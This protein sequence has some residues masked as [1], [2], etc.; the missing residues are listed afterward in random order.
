MESFGHHAPTRRV[1]KREAV[2]NLGA[3]GGGELRGLGGT[4]IV[5]RPPKSLSEVGQRPKRAR[6]GPKGFEA[7]VLLLY[8][9]PPTQGVRRP[10]KEWVTETMN[11]A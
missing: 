4:N 11:E 5:F 8:S 2:G 3:G 10:R 7:L 9:F 1:Q 6:G